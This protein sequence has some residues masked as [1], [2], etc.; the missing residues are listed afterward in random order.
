[1]WKRN[2]RDAAAG[3]FF[4]IC[5]ASAAVYSGV[6]YRLGTFSAMGPGMFPLLGGLAVALL[7]LAIAI[8]ALLVPGGKPEFDARAAAAVIGATALFAATAASFGLVLATF[9]LTAVSMLGS[10]RPRP[11]PML[12]LASILSAVAYATFNLGLGIPLRAWNWPF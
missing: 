8:P 12:V 5:G 1:M 6:T 7:G 11:L 9:L 4:L 10:G 2:Y 3:S